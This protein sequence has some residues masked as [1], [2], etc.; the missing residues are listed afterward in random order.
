MELLQTMFENDPLGFGDY[1]ETF[2]NK[3]TLVYCTKTDIDK[4]PNVYTTGHFDYRWRKIT[5]IETNIEQQEVG[6]LVIFSDNTH[7]YHLHP[8]EA[9]VILEENK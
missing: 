8:F 2:K 3:K 1:L 7:K 4:E 5:P 9:I 6:R